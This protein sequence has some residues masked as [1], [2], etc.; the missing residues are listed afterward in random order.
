[1]S[2]CIFVWIAA[3][4]PDGGAGQRLVGRQERQRGNVGRHRAVEKA[5][6]ETDEE[7][8]R[9]AVRVGGGEHR[10]GARSRRGGVAG[11]AIAHIREGT[12]ACREPHGWRRG[13]PAHAV[14]VVFFFVVHGRW[15]MGGEEA[16]RTTLGN[17]DSS[18][19]GI[20][21]GTRRGHEREHLEGREHGCCFAPTER[22]KYVTGRV[23]VWDMVAALAT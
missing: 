7:T 13:L 21:R 2:Q 12:G 17:G 22:R 18:R 1:M 23:R 8:Q 20:I 6:E 19:L 14:R 16:V 11:S 15:Q 9:R 10:G 3:G 4:Q 5:N